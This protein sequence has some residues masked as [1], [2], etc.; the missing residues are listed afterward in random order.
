MTGKQKRKIT[1]IIMTLIVPII[2]IILFGILTGGRSVSLRMFQ[3]TARQ[4]V[5]PL[6]VAMGLV[7][8][9]SLGMWDFSAGG[10]MIAS[11]IIGGNLMQLTGTGIPGLIFFCIVIGM[12]LTTFT[13]FLN[14]RLKV[15][16]M[17]LTIALVFVY[18]SLP[19]IIFS[20]GVKLKLNQTILASSPYI[21]IV[22]IVMLI[23]FYIV[24]DM[25]THGHNIRA[26]GGNNEIA[27]A[28]GLNSNKI[29]QLG[30]TISGIFLGIA[31]ALYAS[32]NG[33]VANVSSLSSVA[34]ILDAMMSVFLAIFLQKYC[35]KAIALIVASYTMTTITNG[36][37]AMGMST[38]VRE[39]TT[40]V[41]LLVLLA[42]SANEGRIEQ[43]KRDKAIIQQAN[44]NYQ[45]SSSS[46]A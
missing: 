16:V 20:S 25:S 27:T 4:S 14:N 12:V 28:A 8:N 21:F 39:I 3:V 46:K 18:E 34:T 1:N 10:V 9:M 33:Q 17:V 40:G 44:L 22:G 5:I 2:I 38:T 26:L 6:L 24:N 45:N 11:A 29:I 35:T 43:Y 15:P 41:L 7:G 42:I 23:F 31:G 19:R 32:Q 13:G 37:V 30:F 36:F